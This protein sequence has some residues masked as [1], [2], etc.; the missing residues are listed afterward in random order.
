MT[1]GWSHW[2]KEGTFRIEYVNLAGSTACKLSF[3]N[4]ELGIY[5]YPSTAAESVSRG[6]HDHAL[7]FKASALSVP[8]WLDE[9]NGFK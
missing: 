2:T 6:H 4:I 3:N 5:L 7:G 8:N 9:W 1:G